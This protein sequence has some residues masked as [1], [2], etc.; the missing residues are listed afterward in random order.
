MLYLLEHQEEVR[1]CLITDTVLIVHMIIDFK[2]SHSFF[3]GIRL[4]RDSSSGQTGWHL[5]RYCLCKGGKGYVEGGGGCKKGIV[6]WIATVV[7]HVFDCRVG[8]SGL[9]RRAVPGQAINPVTT[10]SY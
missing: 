3:S 2:S 10:I 4:S 5:T 1:R 7:G 6:S 9:T 8:L